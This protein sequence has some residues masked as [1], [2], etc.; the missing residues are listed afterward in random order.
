[1]FLFVLQGLRHRDQ[2]LLDRILMLP[3]LAVACMLQRTSTLTRTIQQMLSASPALSGNNTIQS[4]LTNRPKNSGKQSD[5]T[6]LIFMCAYMFVPVK[7]YHYYIRTYL[8]EVRC[9]QC[10][11]EWIL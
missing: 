6:Q 10:G 1:M 2:Y 3:D 9:V 11:R 5:I 7:V 4:S 8:S